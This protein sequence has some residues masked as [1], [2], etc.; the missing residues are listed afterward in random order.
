MQS[1]EPP[2]PVRFLLVEDDD[3]HADLIRRSLREHKVV[4]QIDRVADGEAAMSFLRKEKEF[5]QASRPDVILLD[6]KLP[7]LDGHEVLEAI[8]SD[9]R[10]RS[11]PVVILT[12]SHAEA[13]VAKAYNAHANSY[14]VKPIDFGQF[15]KL[16]VG[17]EMYWAVW[18]IPSIHIPAVLEP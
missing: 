8:K 11:I 16:V 1:P 7:K 3:D 9:A 10:L 17:L 14:V 6:L 12:T 15:H 4:N 18:N 13:D 5:T 2:R